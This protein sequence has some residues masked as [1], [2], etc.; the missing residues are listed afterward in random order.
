MKTTFSA[1]LVFALAGST[2]SATAE[3]WT[4]GYAGGSFG[5]SPF[6]SEQFEPYANFTVQ[7]SG[8][9]GG[10]YGGYLWS[11]SN[12]LFGIEADAHAGNLEDST[13]TGPGGQDNFITENW[14]ASLRGVV[15]KDMG[16][17]LLYGTAGA[18]AVN[19]DQ[20]YRNPDS[21]VANE[22]LS[23]WTLGMGAKWLFKDDWETKV[24]YIYSD[25]GRGTF[26]CSV[27]GPSENDYKTHTV[28]VGF[29]RRF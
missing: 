3:D 5:L 9:V 22:T 29:A 2:I 26:E 16:S 12:L 25:F 27:C 24:E 17:Y 15:G 4:G 21:T 14:R 6:S 18:A 19:L 8:V 1:L 13:P 20:Q 28:T 23:G 11:S 10:V 7:G